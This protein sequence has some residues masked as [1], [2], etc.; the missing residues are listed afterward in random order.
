MKSANILNKP[1][2]KYLSFGFLTAILLILGCGHSPFSPDA[3]MIVVSTG[4]SVLAPVPSQDGLTINSVLPS[5]SVT[6]KLLQ[7]TNVFI[8]GYSVDYLD[9]AG[10]LLY[11][12]V[13]LATNSLKVMGKLSAYLT[14]STDLSLTIPVYSRDVYYKIHPS[15]KAYN[16]G[17][18]DLL[19]PVSAVVTFYG[20]D[21]NQNRVSCTGYVSLT[22]VPSSM[23]S[24]S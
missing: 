22:T 10:V 11:T 21:A 12:K 15:D 9:E 20:T 3:K 1:S 23:T 16:S 19:S 8:D 4:S 14:T 7:G 24:T 17:E 18:V 13:G 2:L 5:T 6:L